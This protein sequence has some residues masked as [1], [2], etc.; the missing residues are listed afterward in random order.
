[1]AYDPADAGSA[2][3]VRALFDRQLQ[4]M[5]DAGPPDFWVGETFSHLGEALLFIER[6]K[7]TGLPVMATMCFEQPEPRSYEGDTPAECARRLADAGADVVGV[8]CLNGPE[9]QLPIAVQMKQAVGSTPVAAQPVAYRT[10]EQRPDFT[11][12]PNFPYG[13]SPMQLARGEVADYAGKALGGR[14]DV[15]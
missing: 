15:I 7:A 1:W 5:L 3:H 13:L 14:I 2:D 9:Q 4:D 8:N 10:S 11:S 6:A 12:Y